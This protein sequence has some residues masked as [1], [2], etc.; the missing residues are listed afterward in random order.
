MGGSYSSEKIKMSAYSDPELRTV[1]G[2][3][4]DVGM[5]VVRNFY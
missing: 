1:T 2:L 4:T 3:R 5:R